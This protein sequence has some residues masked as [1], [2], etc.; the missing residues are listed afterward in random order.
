MHLSNRPGSDDIVGLYIDGKE[1]YQFYFEGDAL[2]L[3]F[4]SDIFNIHN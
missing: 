3:D 4:D 1:S 2:Y